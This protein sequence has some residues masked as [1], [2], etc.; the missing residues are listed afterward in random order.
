MNIL[1]H[2]AVVTLNRTLIALNVNDNTGLGRLLIPRSP[3]SLP[4][5]RVSQHYP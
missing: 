5:P 2:R 1:D 4:V 3:P